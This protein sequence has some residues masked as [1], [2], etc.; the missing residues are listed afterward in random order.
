M[1]KLK[2][3]M[4]FKFFGVLS[5]F[6]IFA[7]YLYA[8]TPDEGMWTFDNPPVKQLKEKYGFVPTQEWLD[9]V[10]LSSVRFMDGGSG[11]FVSPNGLVMTNH[12][13]AVGQLQKLSTP[14]KDLVNT[15]FYARSYEEEL[16]CPDLELNVLVEMENVTDRVLAAA[17]EGM[18]EEEAL[19]AR[20]AE[21]AK[22][23]KESL[24]KTGLRS[25]VVELYHGGEYWLYRYK[26]YTDVRLVFAPERQAAYFGGDLDNFTYP[27]Y[28]LDVAFFRVYEDDKPAQIKHYFTWNS[29]G[30]GENE[31]VF[32]S[33]NPGSTNRLYTMAQIKFQRDYY[34]PLILDYINRRIAILEEYAKQ[35]PEQERQALIQIFG[36]K[37]AQKALSGEYKGLLNED[38]IA[39]RQALED[40][41]RT[42]IKSNPDWEAAYGDAWETISKLIDQYKN[43]V[44]P[45]FFRRIIG[46]RLA[47]LALQ[48]VRY[49][50]EIEK[51]DGERLDGYHDSQLEERK[52]YLLSPAPIYKGLEKAN[53][54]GGLAMSLEYLGKDDPFVK[55][56]LKGKSP[57]E[58]AKELIE[59][60]KLDD[61]DYRKKLLEG[62]KKAV[63]KSQDP[64][65]VLMRKIDPILREERDWY[66]ENIEGKLTIA[67]EKIAKA[68]FAVYG[69]SAYPDA[70]F[71]LRLAYGTVKGYP[72]N[73]TEA[74]YKTTLYG[75]YDRALSF[76]QKKDF[77]LP[78]RFWNHQ[79]DL[80]L[81]TPVNFV[82][83]CDIIG[84]NSGSPVINK[85]AEIV[86]LIF[87]GNIESLVG[88]FIYNEKTNRAVAVHSAYIIEALRKL[89]D[90]N[91]LVDE[92]LGS[93][94]RAEH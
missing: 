59:K 71:T 4:R 37:N 30:A 12:H 21:I 57:E 36:L 51:P 53:L 52:F 43:R 64:L 85:D 73:G 31:L 14:E 62:G 83:T 91:K 20:E 27:R 15:G 42:K 47:S 32:V 68:R 74:P 46:S 11:S 67:N 80:D 6:L 66:K 60:T 29:K 10:R 9:H 18:S 45:N 39:T 70:T 41:L 82:S 13:V 77:W 19:K 7:T 35:G 5:L 44:K 8:H 76:D 69:K 28:D 90:A 94:T 56:V 17:K 86:G 79:K 3:L 1:Q 2:D 93:A 16:K 22:I 61:V 84:G 54:A 78:E 26:K 55:M 24:E 81:S 75:L 72:M 38:I 25:N 65:I 49:T 92:I 89:Y 63:Q 33:G 48:I 23:E 50:E 34:Y 88:R 40:E 58:V 87:D